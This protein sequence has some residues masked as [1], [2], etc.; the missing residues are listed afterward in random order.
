VT[1]SLSLWRRCAV[2]WSSAIAAAASPSQAELTSEDVRR[3]HKSA[4]AS[5]DGSARFSEKFRYTIATSF[6]LAP[7]LSISLYDTTSADTSLHA[8]CGTSRLTLPS[9]CHEVS[10]RI[11]G[12][13]PVV[14]LGVAMAVLVLAFA[15]HWPIAPVLLAL[16]AADA[17]TI[18]PFAQA[19]IGRGPQTMQCLLAYAPDEHRPRYMAC[20]VP[21]PS[22]VADARVRMQTDVL[23]ETRKFVHSAQM[24]DRGINSAL[25]AIQE[26]ELVSRGA[27]LTS[28]LPPISRIEAAAQRNSSIYPQRLTA[29]R[30]AISNTL[31]EVTFHC[32]AACERIAPFVHEDELALVRGLAPLRHKP[33]NT[34]TPKRKGN[35]LDTPWHVRGLPRARPFSPRCAPT[36]R[37]PHTPCTPSSHNAEEFRSTPTIDGPR[38]DTPHRLSLVALRDHFEQMHATRQTVLHH[39]LALDMAMTSTSLE[40]CWDMMVLHGVLM[41]LS[42]V[43]KDMTARTTDTLQREMHE[44]SPRC[45]THAAKGHVGLADCITEMS[46]ML[47]T[48]QCRLQVCSEEL[49]LPAPPPLHADAPSSL[50]CSIHVQSMFEAMR[51]DLLALSS[52][53]EAGQRIIE[54]AMDPSVSVEPQA[55]S[56]SVLFTDG[57]CELASKNDEVYHSTMEESPPLVF[58]PLYTPETPDTSRADMLTDLLLASTNAAELPAPG[59]EEVF[60]GAA[61]H[62]TRHSTLPRAERLRHIREERARRAQVAEAA[63]CAVTNPIAMVTELRDVLQRR[64]HVSATPSTPTPA[65]SVVMDT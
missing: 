1:P 46:R 61:E 11:A 41:P 10:V 44:P 48:L 42:T 45:E 12:Q 26:V 52:E 25:A 64:T 31:D 32:R 63:A 27:R 5:D 15:L 3:A 9:T 19:Y 7:T 57:P 24:M 59:T 16:I 18:M 6:L 33:N 54:A 58:S 13:L 53:W 36:P 37:H 34:D 29:V 17:V 8:S 4:W 65:H 62:C 49:D 39:L 30:K 35:C 56:L 21:V 55:D 47:R 14:Q 20:G 60:E 51:T 23:R 38:K 28:P 40:A 50:D 43:F 2:A 22:W